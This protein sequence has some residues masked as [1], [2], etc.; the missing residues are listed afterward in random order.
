MQ[1]EEISEK[2]ESE[3]TDVI[4]KDNIDYQYGSTNPN[5]EIEEQSNQLNDQDATE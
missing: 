3:A 5:D 1:F 4:Q 2:N